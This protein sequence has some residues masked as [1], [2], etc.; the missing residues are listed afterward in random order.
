MGEGPDV[1]RLIRFAI[2]LCAVTTALSLVASAPAARAEEPA[3]DAALVPDPAFATC[4]K[5]AAKVDALTEQVLAGL[6]DVNCYEPADEAISDL[7]GAELL[8]S[9]TDFRLRSTALTDVTPL[10][11]LDTLRTLQLNVPASVEL[12]PL[13][14]LSG[15]S[16]LALTSTPQHD[17]GFLDG[18]T[19]DKLTLGATGDRPFEK[20]G[21]PVI[22]DVLRIYGPE[23][24]DL[25]D[26]EGWSAPRVTVGAPK[27]TDVTPILSDRIEG[28]AITETPVSDLTSVG[29]LTGLTLLTLGSPT[30]TDLT[31]LS[32]LTSLVTLHLASA[33]EISDLSPLA[34]LPALET[35]NVG[36][37]KVTDVSVAG[38]MPSLK[39]LYLPHTKVT[40]LGP[41]GSLAGLVDLRAYG[42]SLQDIEALRGATGL[43]T[44][45]LQ[46]AQITDI[47]PLADLPKG[48][49]LNL[50]NNRIHD[51]SPL[52]GWSGDFQGRDQ[53]VTLPD[54]VAEASYPIAMRDEKGK[55]LLSFEGLYRDG[56][57]HYT[58]PSERLYFANAVSG[59]SITVTVHQKVLKGQKFSK[60]HKPKIVGGKKPK[61]G[62]TL[63]VTMPQW[64]PAPARYSYRWFRDGYLIDGA[65]G[66][67]YTL[68]S[69]DYDFYPQVVV[70]GHRD[71]YEASWTASAYA[72]LV[73]KGDF[74]STPA[75]K[76][77]GTRKV[78]KKL[79]ATLAWSPKPTTVTYQ[80]YRN[81][82]KIKKA[83]KSTY[84]LT[85]ADRGKRITVK[86]TGKKR[87]YHTHT[88]TSAKTAKIAKA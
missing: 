11:Q 2:K 39:T 76:I 22:L 47:S 57:L 80:W 59:A 88:R 21:V 5:R 29:R 36:S 3:P 20:A 53:T 15:L 78:G 6:T 24:T 25:S 70:G 49:N 71:G 73:G 37:T 66:S 58:G 75:P 42:S 54:L 44:V 69:A 38:T 26:F 62:Q 56:A 60:T 10:A 77:T 65:T 34:G 33:P 50:E 64:T 85:K 28:L 12:A 14:D 4:L 61:V 16:S 48:A 41:A 46:D 82:T 13:A 87:G 63:S 32:N 81:G 72:G 45:L 67:T 7:T 52:A 86:V 43:K 84:K 30:L 40:S 1:A 68:T 79:T 19:L 74:A 18:M 23:L 8:T 31:P 35:L 55:P 17:L 83:T 51:F 9:V 27:A